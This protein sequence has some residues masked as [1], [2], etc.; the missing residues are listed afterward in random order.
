MWALLV[1]LAIVGVSIFAYDFIEYQFERRVLYSQTHIAVE[2]C[3]A[4]NS[5]EV[6]SEDVSFPIK[7]AA[8]VVVDGTLMDYRLNANTGELYRADQGQRL[9]DRDV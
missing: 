7:Q 8:E 3:V 4:E 1:L 5:S 6:V 9:D 2:Q